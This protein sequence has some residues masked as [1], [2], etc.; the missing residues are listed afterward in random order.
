VGYDSELDLR[1]QVLRELCVY[2]SPDSSGGT[3]FALQAKGPRFEPSMKAYFSLI[4][5]QE[6]CNRLG[7]GSII[8]LS[9]SDMCHLVYM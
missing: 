4:V 8:I 5:L 1:I 3:A 6:V 2:S 9:G 7:N